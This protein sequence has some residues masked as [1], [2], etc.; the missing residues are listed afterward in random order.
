MFWPRVAKIIIIFGHALIWATILA[1]CGKDHHAFWPRLNFGHPSVLEIH[2]WILA[3]HALIFCHACI[4]L[5]NLDFFAFGHASLVVQSWRRP[6]ARPSAY[7]MWRGCESASKAV[8][9][10]SG[11]AG[12]GGD[13]SKMACPARPACPACQA[14]PT[15]LASVRLV[16]EIHWTK[17]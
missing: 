12:G 3:T 10:S 4:I 17:W 16:P 15:C 7:K 6:Q 5:V 8:M 11:G 14:C 9:E 2:S 13:A 1:A